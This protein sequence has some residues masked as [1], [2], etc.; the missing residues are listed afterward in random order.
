MLSSAQA[1]D[2]LE[3]AIPRAEQ[4]PRSIIDPNRQPPGK[5]KR[6]SPQVPKTPATPWSAGEIDQLR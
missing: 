4:L 6:A 2:L 3:E 1:A 5:Q